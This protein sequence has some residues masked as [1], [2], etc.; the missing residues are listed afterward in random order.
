[1][2]VKPNPDFS[3]RQDGRSGWSNGTTQTS[4]RFAAP[5]Q[6]LLARSNSF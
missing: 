2:I 5:L 6:A 3:G 4:R 1:M